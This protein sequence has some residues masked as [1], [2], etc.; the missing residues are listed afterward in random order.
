MS[1][2][3]S[4]HQYMDFF[5][6]RAV[7]LRGIEASHELEMYLSRDSVAES[8]MLSPSPPLVKTRPLDLLQR[9]PYN[10]YKMISLISQYIFYSGNCHLVTKP[11]PNAAYVSIPITE[12]ANKILSTYFF[13]KTTI[14]KKISIVPL[15]IFVDTENV[16]KIIEK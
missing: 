3:G 14:Q 13:Y 4:L 5:P 1:V 15:I 7:D 8:V 10:S 11:P 9:P 6:L 16:Y 2:M 12:M